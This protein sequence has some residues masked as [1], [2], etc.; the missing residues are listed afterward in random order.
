MGTR[1]TIATTKTN[2]ELRK[3]WTKTAKEKAGN[4]WKSLDS[5]GKNSL[6]RK[7]RKEW[8]KVNVG[9]VPAKTTYQDFLSRQPATFQDEV[10]GK[11]KGKL[12]RKGGMSLDKFVDRNG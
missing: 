8:G 12:F 4:N 3:E 9:Q 1:G 5:K 10:L 7:E 6:I 11:T 2:K